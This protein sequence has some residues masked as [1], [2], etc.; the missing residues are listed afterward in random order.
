MSQASINSVH[1]Y[2]QAISLPGGLPSRVLSQMGLCFKT[3]CFRDSHSLDPLGLSGEGLP[4]QW[5]GASLP[6]ETFL[7]SCSGKCSEIMANHNTQPAPGVTTLCC[8]CPNTRKHVCS[9]G[10]PGTFTC[11]ETIWPLP[12]ALQAG[13]PLLPVWHTDSSIPTA[14]SWGLAL[15]ADQSTSRC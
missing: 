11:E 9:L 6:Q 14:C 13:E 1:S 3:L 2:V 12:N 8:L 5:L 15:L 10:S 4:K 7:R